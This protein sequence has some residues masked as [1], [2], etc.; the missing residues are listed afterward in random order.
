[1]FLIMMLIGA[2]INGLIVGLITML[3]A[4]MV[5]KEAPEFGDAFKACFFAAI[6]NGLVQ[7]ALGIAMPESPF[8][9]LGAS[10]LLTYGVY[11]VLFQMIIG[12]TLGQAAAVAAV[13]SLVLLILVIGI[14][15]L[16]GLVGVAASV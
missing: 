15:F 10:L 4:K 11:V 3:A 6:V 16:I 14:G 9:I 8:L 12:Y 7:F 1:M 2:V 13:A 5:V